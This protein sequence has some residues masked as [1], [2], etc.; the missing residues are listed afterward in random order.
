M[1][2]KLISK[3]LR[4]LREQHNFT[5]E[6]LAFELLV[7]RQA[8]SKWETQSALPDLD[9]LLRLS[10]LYKI[11]VNEILEPIIKK[12][13]LADFEE[14]PKVNQTRLK[15]VLSR[16]EKEEIVLAAMGASPQVNEFLETLL[17]EIDFQHERERI[18]KVKLTAVEDAQ[19]HIVSLINL[20]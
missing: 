5:Q 4:T 18:G 12:P 20:S 14:L 17:P 16:L 11:T 3:Y 19:N 6:S 10:K 15:E 9:T 8:V 1:D 13:Y 2:Q 7:S